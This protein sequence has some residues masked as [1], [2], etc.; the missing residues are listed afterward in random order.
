MGLQV[1]PCQL[2]TRWGIMLTNNCQSRLV[3]VLRFV[4]QELV[5]VMTE[6]LN[7]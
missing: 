6:E 5:A 3:M 1:D 4:L 2:H 7:R